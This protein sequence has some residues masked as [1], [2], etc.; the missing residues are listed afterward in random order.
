MVY[1][2]CELVSGDA[3]VVDNE[4]LTEIAWAKQ[5]TLSGYVPYGF[6]APVQKHLDQAL[7]S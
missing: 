2:A 3:K 5:D 7:H 1:V 4:E 6:Y